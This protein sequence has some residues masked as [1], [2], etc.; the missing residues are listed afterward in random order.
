MPELTEVMA[1]V[2]S[3]GLHARPAAKLVQTV[4]QFESDVQINVNGQRVNA[5]SIMGL[6]TLAAAQGTRM[7]VTVQ[8]ADA[9]QAMQAVREL[10]ASGFGES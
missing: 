9:E 7:T 4:L 3:M 6:L 8:G 5:K 10:I 2:N 1:V